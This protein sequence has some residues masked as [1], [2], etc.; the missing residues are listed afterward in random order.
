MYKIKYK[1]IVESFEASLARNNE[2]Q[3]E[4]EFRAEPKQYEDLIERLGGELSFL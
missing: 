3:M 1:H 2:E 4:S